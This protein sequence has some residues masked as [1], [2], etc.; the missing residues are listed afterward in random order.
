MEIKDFMKK[1][2]EDNQGSGRKSVVINKLKTRNTKLE[3]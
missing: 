2:S 3:A 1:Q